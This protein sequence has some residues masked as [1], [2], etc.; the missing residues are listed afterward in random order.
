MPPV[1]PEQLIE[2]GNLLNILQNTLIWTSSSIGTGVNDS[3]SRTQSYIFLQRLQRFFSIA[4]LS[5]LDAKKNILVAKCIHEYVLLV[6]VVYIYTDSLRIKMLSQSRFLVVWLPT[7][8]YTS[9]LS[10][11]L[12]NKIKCKCN[13]TYSHYFTIHHH[14]YTMVQPL[15]SRI[16]PFLEFGSSAAETVYNHCNY[17]FSFI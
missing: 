11:T 2:V 7:H 3:P 17:F 6:V 10:L 15:C 4:A 13:W 8:S 14:Q 9:Q 12:I 16:T 5:I 1:S